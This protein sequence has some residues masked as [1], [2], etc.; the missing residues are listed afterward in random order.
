VPIRLDVRRRM[1]I[2]KHMGDLVEILI[3]ANG[4]NDGEVIDQVRHDIM[5]LINRMYLYDN[6]DQ[7][8]ERFN[9]LGYWPRVTSEDVER[10]FP[11]G[12]PP[13]RGCSWDP[14]EEG[15]EGG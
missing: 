14:V 13:W 4:L 7:V 2:I 12:L 9:D 11:A 15:E 3:L 10:I 1:E 5:V 8:V 6:V